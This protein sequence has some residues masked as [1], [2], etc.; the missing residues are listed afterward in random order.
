VLN[1]GFIS[2]GLKIVFSSNTILG[3][4]KKLVLAGVVAFA[5]TGCIFYDVEPRYDQRDRIVGSFFVDE[6]SQTFNGYSSYQFYISKTAYRDEI[7]IDNFYASGIRVRA[8]V[9]SSKITIPYQVVDGYEIEGTG[10]IYGNELSLFYSVKDLYNTGPT[11]FC[12]VDA[13]LIY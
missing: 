8:N 11:D 7:F 1:R 4:M 2:I 9:Y 3:Q 12:D 5:L 6:Y 13:R 10:T